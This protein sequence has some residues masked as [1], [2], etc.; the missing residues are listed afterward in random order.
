MGKK[1]K[2][3]KQALTAKE[4]KGVCLHCAFFT[5]HGDKW[6]EWRADGDNVSQDAFNDLV[7]SAV[8]IVA[9]I[10]TMLSPLDQMQ[11]QSRVMKSFMEMQGGGESASLE[12][13]KDIAQAIMRS[14]NGGGP[15]KH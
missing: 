10:F 4:L 1:S 3:E 11:F 2:A 7:R 9:E 15:T 12:E 8:K 6:P 14:V 5:M 13:I